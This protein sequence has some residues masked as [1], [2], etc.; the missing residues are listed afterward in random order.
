MLTVGEQNVL[1]SSWVKIRKMK[2]DIEDGT[3]EDD[4]SA[5]AFE[6]LYKLA[7]NLAGKVRDLETQVASVKRKARMGI[8]AF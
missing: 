3:L 8:P 2:A 5:K 6:D 7:N 1:H 4:G